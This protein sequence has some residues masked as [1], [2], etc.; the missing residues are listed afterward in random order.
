MSTRTIYVFWDSG[1]DAENDADTYCQLVQQ[2][3][4]A[5]CNVSCK[6]IDV[7]QSNDPVKKY[8]SGNTIELVSVKDDQK[9]DNNTLP[10]PS[11]V[12]NMVIALCQ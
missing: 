4:P 9:Q 6:K 10:K 11:E 7:F 3:T 8:W 1:N 5:S 2:D 12:K